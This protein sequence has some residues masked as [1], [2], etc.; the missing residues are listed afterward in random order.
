MNTFPSCSLHPIGERGKSYPCCASRSGDTPR[1]LEKVR[2]ALASLAAGLALVCASPFHESAEAQNPCPSGNLL[3]NASIS[4]H[5]DVYD[6]R[7]I[8][9]NILEIHGAAWSSS[10][11][12][13]FQSRNSFVVFDL[14]TTRELT[15]FTLQGDNNDRF[16]VALSLDGT[17]WNEVWTTPTVAHN[18]LQLRETTITPSHARFVKISASG[19]DDFVSLSELAAFCQKSPHQ[20][21]PQWRSSF[22]TSAGSPRVAPVEFRQGAGATLWLWIWGGLMTCLSVLVAARLLAKETRPEAVWLPDLRR[23]LTRTYLTLD[24][25]T[26]GLFR[27]A[28]GLL[29]FGDLFGWIHYFDLLLSNNGL[30]A[31]RHELL[32]N[33]P[34]SPFTLLRWSH[35]D[36][37][38]WLL[39]VLA[40]FSYGAFTV[41]YRTRIAQLTTWVCV[42]SL[43][44]AAPL[45]TNSGHM[46]MRLLL[47]WT[48]LLPLGDRFSL[49]RIRHSPWNSRQQPDRFTSVFALVLPLQLSAVYFFNVLHKFD[50]TWLDGSFLSLIMQDPSITTGLGT[51][52]SE[53]LP[54]WLLSLC[55]VT[56]LA[57]EAAAPFL[58]LTPLAPQ[59]CRV[60]AVALLCILHLAIALSM[61]LEIFSCAMICFLILMLPGSSAE[62][63]VER[64]LRLLPWPPLRPRPVTEEHTSPPVRPAHPRLRLASPFVTTTFVL[65]F[66]TASLSQLI[67]ENEPLSIWFNHRPIQPLQRILTAL[68]TYQGWCMFAAC[69]SRSA[70]ATYETLILEATDASGN[71]IDLVRSIIAGE[72]VPAPRDLSQSPIEDRSDI[73]RVYNRRLIERNSTIITGL[74]RY[75][76]SSLYRRLPIIAPLQLESYVRTQPLLRPSSN[77]APLVIQNTAPDLARRLGTPGPSFP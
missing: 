68:N 42:I 63:L 16:H 8:N 65:V 22:Q 73:W 7:L 29:L 41:G 14:Q 67:R 72:L 28:M 25:R 64:S 23:Y 33:D 61:K 18:G 60:T 19:G 13:I 35:N 76:Q 52:I 39:I 11:A 58:L 66:G 55:T 49:D 34:L 21:S 56:T 47:T 36:R 45:L 6:P 74:S 75:L 57:V 46:I 3:A 1:F 62:R 30:L 38:T 70:P 15:G 31:P 69:G 4:S 71:R 12:S 5:H 20:K 43:H 40:I 32:G 2:L 27:I 37:S 77:T 24:R 51:Y 48:L 10:N 59:L 17:V 54:L 9:D 53:L 50:D 26:L 44:N